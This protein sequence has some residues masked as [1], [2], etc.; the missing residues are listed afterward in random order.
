ML[1]ADKKEGV[2]A[3]YDSISTTLQGFNIGVKV[4]DRNPYS[5]IVLEDNGAPFA[6][7]VTLHF[8]AT[9]AADMYKTDFW[10]EVSADLNFMM[11]ALLGS[12]IQEALD[13]VVDSLVA[14]S[15]GRKPEGM[16]F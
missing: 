3:D 11:K 14:V 13:K 9:S 5:K 1:P 10:I 16:D 8:D 12:K 4:K 7:N 6:F 2:E 15:E